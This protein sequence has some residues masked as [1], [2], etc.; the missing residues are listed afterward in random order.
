[1]IISNEVIKAHKRIKPFARQTF[2]EYSPSFS[3]YI[4]GNVWFKLENQQ[5]TGSFKVRGALNKIL[6]LSGGQPN[7]GVV[8]A[9]TGNHG[10]AVAY[11]LKQTG[12]SGIVFVPHNASPSKM[13]NIKKWGAKIESYGD[14]GVETEAYARAFAEQN[15]MTFI[16]PYNDLQVIGGQ[17][18]IGLELVAQAS[19]TIDTV[20]CALGGGG[21]ISGLSGFLKSHW[22]KV[23]VVGCSPLNSKVMIESV[24]HGQILDLPSEPTLSDGTAGGVEPGSITF[25][26]VSHLVD[27]FETVTESEIE[28]AMQQFIKE[29]CQLIE[30]AAG[31]A[32]ASLI[33]QRDRLRGKNVI[34]IICGGNISLESLKS[35]L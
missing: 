29:Q 26:Y 5:H 14:D 23:E 22:P 27:R 2:L 24:N 35:V 18:T 12:G 17:G 11:A 8:T 28:A 25:E 15:Q 16:S 10:A 31:V 33:K 7:V 6:G 21:L 1:M 32:V 19:E 34:V 3:Q 30:G 4:A 13:A 9:S 20:F